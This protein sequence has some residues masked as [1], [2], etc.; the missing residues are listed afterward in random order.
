VCRHGDHSAHHHQHPPRI[1]IGYP[2][3]YMYLLE[4]SHSAYICISKPTKPTDE[5]SLCLL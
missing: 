1:R 4:S 2:H 5:I 3:C